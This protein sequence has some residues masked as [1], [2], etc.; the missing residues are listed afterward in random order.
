MPSRT[1][2]VL[3]VMPYGHPI[4]YRYHKQLDWWW[5]CCPTLLNWWWFIL[6]LNLRPL[7]IAIYKKSRL[8]FFD[9][10]YEILFADNNTALPL[11]Q[12]STPDFLLT[13]SYN[14]IS[15]LAQSRSDHLSSGSNESSNLEP[16]KPLDIQKKEAPGCTLGARNYNA[17]QITSLK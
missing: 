8:I 12:C 15:Q 2:I 3:K 10:Y 7:D 13:T 17:T 9:K 14:H 6:T 5:R 4:W 16:D 11:Y 1:K